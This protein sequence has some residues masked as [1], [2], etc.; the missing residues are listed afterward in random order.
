MKSNTIVIFCFYYIR[1]NYESVFHLKFF[2]QELKMNLGLTVCSPPNRLQICPLNQRFRDV[3][4]Y[5]FEKKS[6][7]KFYLILSC[8]LIEQGSVNPYK[9]E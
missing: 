6:K 9:F 8:N 2:E 3:T 7:K 4:K 1:K 5:I